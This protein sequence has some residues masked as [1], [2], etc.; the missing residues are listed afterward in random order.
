MTT[1]PTMSVAPRRVPAAGAIAAV[2]VSLGLAT[3]DAQ[4]LTPEETALIA[5]GK[6]VFFDDK[7]SHPSHKQACASCHDAARGWV[8]PNSK[9]NKTTVVAPGAAPH[10]RGD[11]KAPSNAY[12][13]FSPPFA[14]VIGGGAVC[15]T[16]PWRQ[17]LG[18]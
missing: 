13:S 11:I 12:A 9:I 18:R 17:F 6:S 15:A 14:A 10:A 7:L 3:P 1:M 8:L 2:V 5:L 4:A 16:I